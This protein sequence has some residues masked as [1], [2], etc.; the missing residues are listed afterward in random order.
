M[1][2]EQ[3]TDSEMGLSH[4]AGEVRGKLTD[5]LQDA[6]V[7]A[8][9]DAAIEVLAERHGGSAQELK[10]AL[11]MPWEKDPAP[12]GDVLAGAKSSQELGIDD[13]AITDEQVS[14]LDAVKKAIAGE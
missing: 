4:L 1:T 2:E 12:A 10:E 14:A 7:G 8:V 3:K 6:L 13:S 5:A 9:Q 11:K